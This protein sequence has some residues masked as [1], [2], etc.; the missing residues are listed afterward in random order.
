[1][2]INDLPN[3][4]LFIIL[5]QVQIAYFDKEGTSTLSNLTKCGICHY[6]EINTNCTHLH[7]KEVLGIKFLKMVCRKWNCIIKK[8]RFTSAKN[9]IL[10]SNY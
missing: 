5:G 3:D 1:M 7:E 6:S 10:P 2:N 4:C 9:I 8:F